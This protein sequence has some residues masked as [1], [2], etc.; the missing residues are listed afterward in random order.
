M[1]ARAAHSEPGRLFDQ[2]VRAGGKHSYPCLAYQTLT[3]SNNNMIAVHPCRLPMA[4]HFVIFRA[5]TGGV[6]TRILR[7]TPEAELW[8]QLVPISING[9]LE[10]SSGIVVTKSSMRTA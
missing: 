4:E 5:N 2:K 8:Q 9:R 3:S 10:D 7:G 6:L 1:S